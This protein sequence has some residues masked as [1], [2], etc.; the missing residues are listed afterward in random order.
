MKVLI[1][2]V[3][4]SAV[5]SGWLGDRLRGESQ[6][7]EEL[8]LPPNAAVLEHW[9]FGLAPAIAKGYWL[10]MLSNIGG[11]I[12]DGNIQGQS[13]LSAIFTDP[14]H[15]RW[16]YQYLD[17]ITRLA[18]DFEEPYL[19]AGVMFYWYGDDPALAS[20]FLE[21]GW[22]QGV[23]RWELPYYRGL[24]AFRDHEMELASKWMQRAAR[25]PEAPAIVPAVASNFSMRA[26]EVGASIA[27]LEA[28]LATMD[29]DHPFY[30]ALEVDLTT[31]YQIAELNTAVE[32]Y[33]EATGEQPYL[34]QQLVREGFLS[35]EEIVPAHPGEFMF[36]DARIIFVPEEPMEHF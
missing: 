6:F 13:S 20:E 16:L 2:V 12:V 11:W 15:K 4:L 21:R 28:L 9:S 27:I 23:K 1:P 3:I 8:S 22:D 36:S 35:P 26:G 34:L 32:A 10:Q 7:Q 5:L 33:R 29:E 24:F 30:N 25:H 18:P 31:Q 19:Y 14:D 17:G